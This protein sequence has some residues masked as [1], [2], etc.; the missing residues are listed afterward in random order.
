MTTDLTSKLRDWLANEGYPFELK[1]GRTLHQA[2]W[3]ISHAQHYLDTETGKLREVDVQ[4]S[5]GPYIGETKGKGMVSVYLVCECKVSQAK[6]WIVFT[7]R[8]GD[9]ELRIV[10]H[11]T[12]SEPSVEALS[13]AVLTNRGQL[14]SLVMG[15]RIGHG[16]TKALVESRAA[17]PTG[18]FA[19]VLGAMSAA[20]ALSEDHYSSMLQGRGSIKWLAIYLPVVVLLG[21]LF[22]FYLDEA[23][24]EVLVECSR[25]HVLAY[26]PG[27][28]PNPV[29][30]QL[31]TASALP[32]FAVA[33]H[34]EARFL[35]Q[36]ILPE[37]RRIWE[38]FRE[39]SRSGGD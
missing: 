38:A 36:A 37:A 25:A 4:A 33:A 39:R 7:S 29:L 9:D 30:V 26:P 10:S 20:V 1:V 23:G 3:D 6:P 8:H 24:E 22:E 31:V 14:S 32:E 17:D 19:A 2:G 12:P 15:P 16:V 34:R 5:F 18:P 28:H 27:P 13:H 11:L 21:Q 35:A